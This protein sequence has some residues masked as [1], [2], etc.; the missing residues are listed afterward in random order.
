VIRGTILAAL[1]GLA[2][3]CGAPAAGI[4][5]PTAH[6][7]VAQGATLL[8]VRTDEEWAA[9]HLDAAMHVPIASLETR[10]D[11]IPRDHPV[12]VYCASG[13]RSARATEMLRSAGYDA[14]D[15]G[16]MRRWDE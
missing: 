10:L 7:L 13:V 16:G 9:G 12:V 11:E 3:G 6:A 15:L 1:A 14:R 5:G 8:D 2:I 4:D